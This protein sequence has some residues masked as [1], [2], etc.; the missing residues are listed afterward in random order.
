MSCRDMQGKEAEPFSINV[1]CGIQIAVKGHTT[2]AC[3]DAICA[4]EIG[5]NPPAYATGLRGREESPNRDHV[6]IRPIRF[7]RQHG[8]EHTPSGIQNAFGQFGFHQPVDVQI[9]DG[10]EVEMPYQFGTQL[11]Q[12]VIPLVAGFLMQPC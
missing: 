6:G 8:S 9:F 5:I 3:P 7:I 2:G 12:E 11:V 4:G 1:D 10:Y